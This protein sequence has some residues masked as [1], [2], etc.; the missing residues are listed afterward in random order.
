[1][2]SISA[3]RFIIVFYPLKHVQLSKKFEITLH[4]PFSTT[5]HLLT[6]T[7]KGAL[8]Y[9]SNVIIETY[10]LLIGTPS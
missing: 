3:I 8:G 9:H 5:Y 1:M 7:L 6:V 4:V 10:V 2:L